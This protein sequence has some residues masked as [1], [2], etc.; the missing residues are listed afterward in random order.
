VV[1]YS[2]GG[3]ATGGTDYTALTGTVTILA[4]NT[5][6]NN[7]VSGIVHDNLLEDHQSVV[8]T[9]PNVSV[10]PQIA[11]SGTP[12]DLAATVTIA[13]NDSATVSI[14]ANDAS[15]GETPTNNGQFTVSLTQASSTNTVVTYSV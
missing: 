7:D 6:A 10:D 12:A 2:V 5:S 3:T 8:V 14:A 15:A 9:L 11:L 1:T 13:D 4:G